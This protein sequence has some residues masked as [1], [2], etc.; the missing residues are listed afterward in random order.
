MMT[1]L[2]RCYEDLQNVPPDVVHYDYKQHE[3]K[4]EPI[5]LPSIQ[6]SKSCL[7]RQ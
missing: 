3:G 5:D 6:V 4:L 1:P 7:L 2:Q